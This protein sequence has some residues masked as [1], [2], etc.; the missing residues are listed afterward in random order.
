MIVDVKTKEGDKGKE[1]EKEKEREKEN[2]REREEDKDYYALELTTDHIPSLPAEVH[3][4]NACGG[5]IRHPFVC[6]HYSPLSSP[7]TILSRLLFIILIII[8]LGYGE[9]FCTRFIC[10]ILSCESWWT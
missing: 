6:Y 1:K 10:I 3:R 4:V 5:I 2:E 7:S 9:S 8:I